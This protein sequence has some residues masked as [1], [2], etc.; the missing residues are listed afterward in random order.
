MQASTKAAAEPNFLT[1]PEAWSGGGIVVP[2]PR[3]VV[4]PAAV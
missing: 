3:S 2:G 1:G 4:P